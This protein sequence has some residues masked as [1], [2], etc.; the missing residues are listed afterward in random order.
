VQYRALSRIYH[1]DWHDPILMKQLRTSS[2]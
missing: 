2:N 1:P